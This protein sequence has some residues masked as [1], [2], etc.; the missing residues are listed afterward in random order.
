MGTRS[1]LYA[2]ARLIGD[3]QAARKGTRAVGMRIARKA[4]LRQVGKQVNRLR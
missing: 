2:I 3:I 1:L 4:V